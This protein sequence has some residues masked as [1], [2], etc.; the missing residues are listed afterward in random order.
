MVFHKRNKIEVVIIIVPVLF[1]LLMK[2]TVRITTIH[3]RHIE[4][5][6]VNLVIIKEKRSG[7]D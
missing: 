5:G 4:L 1:Q 3:S 2:Q 6:K 7:I